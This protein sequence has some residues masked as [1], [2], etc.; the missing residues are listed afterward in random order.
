MSSSLE[1]QQEE[2]VIKVFK[3]LETDLGKTVDM[4]YTRAMNI[5]IGKIHAIFKKYKGISNGELRQAKI[6]QD[7]NR[8]RIPHQINSHYLTLGKAYSDFL[9]G[10]LE[11]NFSKAVG[12]A[13]SN[14]KTI[15][16]A[17]KASQVTYKP[18]GHLE[19][20]VMVKAVKYGNKVND[21]IQQGISKGH[22]ADKIALKLVQEQGM[23]IYDAKRLARTEV[24]MTMNDSSL[25]TYKENGI[26]FVKWMD[27]TE[28][29]WIKSVG[30][31]KS[32][33]VTVV[34]QYCQDYAS[35]GVNSDG[36]YPI[37]KLPSEIPAHPNCRCTV[38][39]IL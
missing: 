35:G 28:Q 32:G 39:P 2:F 33:K 5:I 26:V 14:L 13:Q 21:I 19:A 7:L 18:K 12:Q 17:S 10:S 29:A 8:Q 15:G 22:G 11:E 20:D 23:Q 31:N 9:K 16:V 1:K 3:G 27:A 6:K 4:P 34:C 37:N 24:A 38:I 30:R 25:D 36:V